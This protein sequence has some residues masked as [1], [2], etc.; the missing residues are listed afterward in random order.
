MTALN[1]FR[2]PQSTSNFNGGTFNEPYPR[3]YS[4]FRLSRGLTSPRASPQAA[5]QIKENPGPGE[6][7]RTCRTKRD[8]LWLNCFAAT[9]RRK[10]GPVRRRGG[11]KKRNE[12][13]EKETHREK[14]KKKY[15]FPRFKGREREGYRFIENTKRANEQ[16]KFLWKFSICK[17]GFNFVCNRETLFAL[18]FEKVALFL[19]EK[20]RRDLGQVNW[21]T[22]C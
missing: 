8:G 11:K 10:G 7:D 21:N 22:L 5:E 17:E 13:G 1:R 4:N 16:K 2:S 12:S 6:S 3:D 14:G 15:F 19:S 9:T 18:M 20:T